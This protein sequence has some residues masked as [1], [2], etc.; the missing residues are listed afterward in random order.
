M[1]DLEDTLKLSHKCNSANFRVN[2]LKKNTHLSCVVEMLLVQKS[3]DLAESF[4]LYN[5]KYT[6]EGVKKVMWAPSPSTFF[7]FYSLHF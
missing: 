6:L 4:L 7:A 5:A 3:C 1:F 2:P